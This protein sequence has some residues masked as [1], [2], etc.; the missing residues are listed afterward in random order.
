MAV[1]KLSGHIPRLP[2]STVIVLDINK[3]TD[4]KIGEGV[5]IPTAFFK[6]GRNL[7]FVDEGHKGQKSE[8]STW[9]R[10]QDDLAGIDSPQ[11]KHR[12]FLIEFSATFG[13]VA[14]LEHAFDRYAKSVVF[15]YAY[16]R[17]HADLYGKDFWHL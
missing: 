11:E 13:Q 7:V 8:E 16:D 2:M 4:K 3:L 6:D 9:K 15:D 14:E 17:F 1:K 12:G 5:S 10:L